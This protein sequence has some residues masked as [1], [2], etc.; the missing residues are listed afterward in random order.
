MI[1]IYIGELLPNTPH[2]EILYPNLGNTERETPFG[3]KIFEGFTEKIV[4]IVA[5]PEEAEYL[6]IPHNYNYVK[7]NLAYL[8]GFAELSE[9]LSKK[10]IVF[11]PGDSDEE[12]P[13]AYAVVFRNSQYKSKVRD[14]EIIMPGFAA[15]LGKKYG[16][17]E[18]P[19][20][21]KPTVGF[22]GWANYR[23]IKEWMSYGIYNLMESL[24]GR[25]VHKKGLYFRR[26]ALR[27]LAKS[28]KIVTNFIIRSSYSGNSKTL[29]VDPIIARK[30]YVDS[31]KNSDFTLSPKGDGNF[32]VR[33]FESLSLGRIPLLIDTDCPLP[34]EDEIDYSE[35][36]LRINY[37]NL[38]LLP[39]I[40]AEYWN[41][42]TPEEHV[43]KQKRCREVYEKYLKIDV[44]FKQTLTPE[45]LL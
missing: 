20:G 7:N 16:L 14:N 45:F 34:L 31:I 29:S 24:V 28:P 5:T 17:L 21:S 44:F 43:K 13:F 12:V 38:P 2:T 19:K 35:F 36:I 42:L 15:D 9:K 40:V 26:A 22:C 25:P 32:S 3:E 18:R 10:V 6:C 33:F 8:A 41:A 39:D 4:E 37:R 11:L 27:L 23:T 1:K 30:E